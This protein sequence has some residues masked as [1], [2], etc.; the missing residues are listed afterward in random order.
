MLFRSGR[1]VRRS[2]SSRRR[3]CLESV[4]LVLVEFVVGDCSDRR[5]G[6]PR[7]RPSVQ[8]EFTLSFDYPSRS[9]RPASGYFGSQISF[10]ARSAGQHADKNRGIGKIRVLGSTRLKVRGGLFTLLCGNVLNFPIMTPVDGM[11]GRTGIVGATE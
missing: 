7:M 9:S 2:G 4:T 5:S 6:K 10:E 11:L 1:L 8:F 3:A